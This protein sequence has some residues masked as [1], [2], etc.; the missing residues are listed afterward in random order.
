MDILEEIMQRLSQIFYILI[1]IC[2]GALLL[3]DC[4]PEAGVTSPGARL[5]VTNSGDAPVKGLVVI[6]PDERIVF[7]D[8]QPGETTGFQAAPGGV[9]NYAAY[10]YLHNGEEVTQPVLDWV[11]ETGKTSGDFTYVIRYDPDEAHIMRISLVEI[12]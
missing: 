12:Q 3:T 4:Q 9:Y 11:G 2:V 1:L 6:F 10:S 8:V 5:R 7:G